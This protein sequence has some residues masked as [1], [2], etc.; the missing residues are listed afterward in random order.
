MVYHHEKDVPRPKAHSQT[1]PTSSG[2]HSDVQRICESGGR[3]PLRQ[4][5]TKG[6]KIELTEGKKSKIECPLREM[7]HEGENIQSHKV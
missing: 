6:T 1:H 3:F 4:N 2:N 5:F 7:I